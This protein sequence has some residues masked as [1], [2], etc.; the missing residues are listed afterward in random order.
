MNHLI[1][2]SSLVVLSCL[3]ATSVASAETI[4]FDEMLPSNSNCCYLTTEY[5]DM[6]VTFVTTDDGSIW[7]GLSNGNPGTWFL[8]G[9]NGPAFLGFNGASFSTRLLFDSPV[10]GFGLD[11]A[12]SVGWYSTEDVFTLEGYLGGVLVDRVSAQPLPFGEWMNVVLVGEIDEVFMV[13]EGP[14]F[15]NTYGIDN[16]NWQLAG[17]SEVPDDPGPQDEPDVPEMMSVDIDVKPWHKRNVVNPMSRG[18]TRV[19]FF[20]SADFDVEAIDMKSMRMGPGTAK[21]KK[22][23]WFH[24]L[25]RDG[26][27]DLVSRFRTRDL[28]LALGEKELCMSG[29]TMDGQPFEGC[30][31]VDTMPRVRNRQADR[32]HRR[33]R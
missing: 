16:L 10:N 22:R 23:A 12:P 27:P 14:S 3:F 11:M 19:A 33:R 13:S 28:G 31:V 32:S 30:D 8:E 20:G 29:M 2:N 18:M 9:T 15:P 5:S 4:T 1:R 7:G 24:D 6:G 25:N 21:M 26:F 17:G